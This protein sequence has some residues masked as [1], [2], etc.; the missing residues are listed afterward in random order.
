MTRWLRRGAFVGGLLTV[1][2]LLSC[3]AEG[4]TDVVPDTQIKVTVTADGSGL[5]GVT[6]ELYEGGGTTVLSSRSTGNTGEATFPGL[7]AGTYEVEITVP[8]GYV[9]TG[10]GPTRQT[11][12]VA[13]EQTAEATFALES[14]DPPGEVVEVHMTSSL[15]FSP[16]E[17]TIAPGTTVRWVNDADIF[18]TITPDGHSEW[19]EGSVGS[20]GETFSHTFQT[21]GTFPYYCSPHRSQGMTGTITV[22]AP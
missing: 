11:V 5:A 10:D 14:E 7:D 13:A 22:S 6:V 18:H 4:G 8:A 17:L 12:M 16:S 1:G 20:A 19:N 3:D 2:V 21:A 15:T 9:V